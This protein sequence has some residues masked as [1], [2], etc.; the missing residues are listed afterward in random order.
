[1]TTMSQDFAAAAG[2]GSI[3]NVPPGSNRTITFEGL[4]ASGTVTY[5]GTVTGVTLTAG[6]TYNCGTVTMEAVPTAPT[7]VTATPGNAQNTISWTAVTG[8]TSY[9]IYWATTTGVSKSSTKIASA[10][11]PYTHSPITNGTTYYYVVTSVNEIGE[12]TESVQVSATPSAAGVWQAMSTTGAPNARFTHTAIWTGSKMIIWGGWNGADLN[13]GAK[14]DPITDTW[15]STTSVTG[16]P[17]ARHA[18]AAIWT[19]SEMIIWGGGSNNTGGRYNPS[20]DSWGTPPTTTGAPSAKN[21][22]AAVWTGSEMIVWG[23]WE[24][25]GYV[26]TGRRYNPATDTWNATPLSTTNAPSARGGSAAVWA[27]AEMLIW[28]GYG[29]TDLNNGGRYNPTT[30]TWGTPLSTVGAPSARCELASVWTGSE[31]IIWGGAN[32]SSG[33]MNNGGQYNPATDTWS[34]AS[35][36]STNAPSARGG[37][38]AVWNGMQMIIWGGYDT[39]PNPI[40]TGGR[41]SPYSAPPT[42]VHDTWQATSTTGAPSVR[43]DPSAVWTGS[44]VIVWGG[45]EGVT[46]TLYNNGMRYNPV[47]D[48]WGSPTSTIGAPG[49]RIGHSAVWTGSEMIVWGGVGAPYATYINPSSAVKN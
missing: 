30:N 18:H 28:G 7:G 12:S 23:G 21:E 39:Y 13:T 31:M 32:H 46:N 14:Y 24:S 40:N 42:L 37:H 17:S 29:G 9:N 33:T 8:A 43:R 10:T 48:S 44:E 27:G 4:D 34:T 6:Q 19:G 1:M 41:Y 26:N 25:T 16:A 35:I 20:T 36:S 45:E 47:T 49:A 15:I 3:T 5:R 38:T 2:S 22:P 11:S